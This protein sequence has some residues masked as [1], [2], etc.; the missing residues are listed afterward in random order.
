MVSSKGI[1]KFVVNK[2]KKKNDKVSR[3]FLRPRQNWKTDLVII[4][5]K[6]PERNGTKNLHL[7]KGN[8]CKHVP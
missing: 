4:R 2:K 6:M 5:P 7:E 3:L 8:Y 1:R